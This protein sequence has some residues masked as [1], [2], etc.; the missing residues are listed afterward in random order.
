M[1][2]MKGVELPINVLIIVA[3][4]LIVLL[5]IVA[6]FFIGWSPFPATVGLESIKNQACRELV[7]E[8]QCKIATADIHIANFDADKDEAVGT[9]DTGAQD[10]ILGT[11]G[12]SLVT[13]MGDNL[14][15]LCRCWYN[16]ADENSCKRICG[17]P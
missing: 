5:G 1:K 10:D 17:C 14:R 4:G 6:L 11:C 16:I 9:V 12:N 3:V 2:G 8:W 15:N 7:Q 13:N